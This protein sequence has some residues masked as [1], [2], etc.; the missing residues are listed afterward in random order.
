MA[1]RAGMWH[2]VLNPTG[3]DAGTDIEIQ[4]VAITPAGAPTGLGKRSDAHIGV[5]HSRRDR[6]EALHDR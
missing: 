1:V 5:D 4:Q 3:T 6:T 2:A